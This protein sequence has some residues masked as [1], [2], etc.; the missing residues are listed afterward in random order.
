VV[1]EA[2]VLVD[3]RVKLRNEVSGSVKE[4]NKV[5]TMNG[6]GTQLH[7]GGRHRLPLSLL[8][9]DG[10]AEAKNVEARHCWVALDPILHVT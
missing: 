1:E 3:E 4:I 10:H 2:Q 6:G 8:T 7:V 5:K 9:R